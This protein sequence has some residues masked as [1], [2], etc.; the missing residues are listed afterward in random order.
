MGGDLVVGGTTAL[1]LHGRAHY[2]PLTRRRA[3]HLHGPGALP[4]RING[5]GAAET[6]QR[7]RTKEYTVL[8]GKLGSLAVGPPPD[9]TALGGDRT[10]AHDAGESGSAR[11]RAGSRMATVS[12]TAPE[13]AR[14][15]RPNARDPMEADPA[16]PAVAGFT[17]PGYRVAETGTPAPRS[18]LP[19]AKSPATMFPIFQTKPE[20][21]HVLRSNRYA[22][23]MENFDCPNRAI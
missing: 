2:P 9:E 1:E 23:T 21:I 5:L 18:T 10:L 13:R 4:L 16:S 14:H 7:H 11:R 3:M 6:L 22:L 15:G 19:T 8:P 20:R 12:P 17:R